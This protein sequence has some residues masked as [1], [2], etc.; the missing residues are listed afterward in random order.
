MLEKIQTKI[1]DQEHC[2][3]CYDY[4]NKDDFLTAKCGHSACKNCWNN[5]LK[6]K[7]E[8][9]ICKEKVRP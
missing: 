5:L 7:L 3:I 2:F 1:E 6:E 8:C 4:F 9:M